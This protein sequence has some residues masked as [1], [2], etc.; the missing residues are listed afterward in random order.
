MKAGTENKTK[1]YIAVVLAVVAVMTMT[2][3]LIPSGPANVPA[4]PVTASGERAKAGPSES[5]D[6]RLHMELLAN[7][8]D[9][10]YE[11]K[12]KNIFRA[13]VE[14]VNIPKPIQSP[15]LP[16]RTDPSKPN[17][18]V[19]P[20]P[21][22]NL[23]YFG[24]TNSKGEKPRAFLSQGD[25]VWIANEG[26]VVNRHYKIVRISPREVEVEDLLNNHRQSIPLTQG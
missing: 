14:V 12:G 18:V 6:P 26:D 19:P 24:T 10:K 2:W 9:V 22:I 7:S 15:I 1:V 20:P 13:G 8:E 17:Y 3:A 4:A 21:P 16:N 23:K 11:G 25:D 5:L